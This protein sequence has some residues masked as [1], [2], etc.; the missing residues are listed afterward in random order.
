MLIYKLS[1][2]FKMIKL[3]NIRLNFDENIIY[4]NNNNL[5][6]NNSVTSIKDFFL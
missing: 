1:V 5:C 2:I 3:I 4:K 6:K